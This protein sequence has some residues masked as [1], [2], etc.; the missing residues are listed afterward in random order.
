MTIKKLVEELKVR[1]GYLK[2]SPTRVAS[3]FKV[4]VDVAIRA[5]REAKQLGKTV[6][7]M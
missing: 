1:P 7:T 6:I 5:I 4:S 3:R 2:S